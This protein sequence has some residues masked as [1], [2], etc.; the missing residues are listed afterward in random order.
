MRGNEGG[1]Y[2][3]F[4]AHFWWDT[5]QMFCKQVMVET[6]VVIEEGEINHIQL[7]WEHLVNAGECDV[8]R[9]C[10]CGSVWRQERR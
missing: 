7:T 5:Q 9:H 1:R 4:D 3:K 10:T 2:S 8:F 6:L